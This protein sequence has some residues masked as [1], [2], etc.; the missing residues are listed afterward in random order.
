MPPTLYLIA[1][2]NGSGKSTFARALLSRI[3][4]PL[5]FVNTDDIVLELGDRHSTQAQVR[6][7]R[8]SLARIARFLSDRK[9]FVHETTL[10]GRAQLEMAERAKRAGWRIDLTFIF[11]R[12]W[13]LS[14]DRVA[15][16]VARGGHDVPR[17]DIERRF[18]RSLENFWAMIHLCDAWDL[19]DNSGETYMAIAS[20]TAEEWV[21]YDHATFQALEAFRRP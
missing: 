15:S 13:L 17:V 2:P 1:G 6:A 10:S 21:V 14:A 20:G 4:P 9:S 7:G 16:R 12:D 19:F 8:A 11:V 5:P 3:Q 18:A